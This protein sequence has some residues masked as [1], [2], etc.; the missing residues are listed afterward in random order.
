MIIAL[1]ND[2]R[3]LLYHVTDLDG[4]TVHAYRDLDAAIRSREG[5]QRIFIQCEA[6]GSWL[7][8]PPTPVVRPL[9]DVLAGE[10]PAMARTYAQYRDLLEAA[11]GAAEL[12]RIRANITCATR[13]SQ[14]NLV[15]AGR[16]YDRADAIQRSKE[17][18]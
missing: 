12:D 13:A 17:A 14:L 2:G 3:G 1:P 16:L 6:D 4:R 8:G 11:P 5:D 9:G 18:S 15:Q 7:T 10:T